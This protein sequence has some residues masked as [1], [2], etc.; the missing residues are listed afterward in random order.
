MGT[1]QAAEPVYA[2]L[3]DGSTVEIRPAG[4]ADYDAVKTMYEAM[5]PDNLYLRFFSLSR[6]AAEQQAR[7]ICREPGPGD[8]SLLAL[9]DGRLAG[10]GSFCPLPEDRAQAEIAFAVAD[11]MHHKGIATLLLEHLVSRAAAQ[12]VTAL[13]A[14]TLAENTD[15]LRVFADAGL[16]VRRKS[17]GGILDLTFPLP[18]ATAGTGLD[19]YLEAVGSRERSAEVASLRHVLAPASVAVIGA[20]RRPGTVG[21]AILDNIRAA[22]F[23]GRLYPVNPHA[24]EVGGLPCVPSPGELPEP[25]DLA[26]IAVPPAD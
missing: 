2:L 11:H 19:S 23:E 9:A 3:T 21:R 10:V 14:Q 12:G 20:S 13:T 16:P 25:V 18:G 17:A 6:V 22:G 8:L 24:G 1:T 5:S 26:V 15:M 7:R 4:P